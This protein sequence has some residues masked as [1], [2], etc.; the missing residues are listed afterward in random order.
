MS[1]GGY[2]L[3]RCPSL[4]EEIDRYEKAHPEFWNKQIGE[5]ISDVAKNA[6]FRD[7]RDTES[8]IHVLDELEVF[9]NEIRNP[10]N[11]AHGN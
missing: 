9:F 7:I 6:G 5:A 1:V 3:E 10:N 11:T 8:V 2:I 4:A